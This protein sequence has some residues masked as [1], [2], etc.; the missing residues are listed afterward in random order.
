MQSDEK[1][2]IKKDQKN[3]WW[4]PAFLIILISSLLY[5]YH[6]N[7]TEYYFDSKYYWNLTN[8][9]FYD[10][11]NPLHILAFPES[12]RGYFFP[13]L[14]G[15]FKYFFPGVWG[16]RIF[17]ALSM[18]FCFSLSLPYAIRG[19]GIASFREFL[20][21]L[22]AYA[23]FMWFWGDS[24]Q[25]PLSDFAPC[26]LLLSAIAFLRSAGKLKNPVC[27]LVFGT[28][29]GV[30]LYTAYNTRPTF[31]YSAL[32]ILPAYILLNRRKKSAILLGLSGMLV[33]ITV[34]ALP[35]CYINRHNGG[36]FSPVV[37]YD[38]VEN[39]VFKGLTTARYETYVGD[40][41]VYPRSGVIF[42][43]GPGWKLIKEAK[44]SAKGFQLTKIFDLFLKYPLD[45][46]GL[47]SRHLFSLLTPIYRTTYISD[48]YSVEPLT[49]VLSIVLWLAAGYSILMQMKE[50]PGGLD[51]LWI[52]ALCVPGLLQ[53]F[54]EPELRFFLPAYLL[55]YYHI[56]AVVDYKML[57]RQWK[58]NWRQTLIV[59]LV[60]FLFWLSL[61]GNILSAKRNGAL[62]IGNHPT[63][64]IS[65]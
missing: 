20:R 33:G 43:D 6:K 64:M 29:A 2:K 51:I 12:I 8:D 54:D 13:S 1:N 15:Y 11:P 14:I 50:K 52:L 37:N 65:K 55:C 31:L 25:Y 7:I 40:F 48:I 45:T 24:M 34:F 47:Y 49:I 46:I 22:L 41:D 36:S 17:A 38:L 62:L 23:V 10:G 4:A 19:R 57:A 35:Q 63:T 21:T 5:A 16:W 9:L 61:T 59:S 27:I 42:E 28:F 58:T 3:W 32:F 39:E 60:I 53:I 18:A 56:C 30:L 26:F 44:I